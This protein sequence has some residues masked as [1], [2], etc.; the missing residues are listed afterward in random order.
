MRQE[1]ESRQ[2]ILHYRPQGESEVN[3][4]LTYIAAYILKTGNVLTP[5]E[6]DLLLGAPRRM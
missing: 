6:M 1:A 2:A 5:K 4:K 3:E